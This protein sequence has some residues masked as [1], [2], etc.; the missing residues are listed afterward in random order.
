MRIKVDPLYCML[1]EEE[2]Q[3]AL[4]REREAMR[5]RVTGTLAGA[6]SGGSGIEG[7]GPV[8]FSEIPPDTPIVVD[9]S[10]SEKG[11]A[12]ASPQQRY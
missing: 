5:L 7:G 11:S 2:E 4:A 10:V 6:E 1:Q 8:E 3:A 12:N 9:M